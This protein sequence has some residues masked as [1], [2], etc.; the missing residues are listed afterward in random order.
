[1]FDKHFQFV[2]TKEEAQSSFETIKQES[3]VEEY[4]TKFEI[5]APK[6][7]YNTEA[8][9]PFFKKGLKPSILDNVYR[10]H[11]VA[12]DLVTWKLYTLA[13]EKQAHNRKKEKERWGGQPGSACHGVHFNTF[14]RYSQ[15]PL[16]PRRP[17]PSLPRKQLWLNTSQWTLMRSDVGCSRSTRRNIWS[18]SGRCFYCRKSAARHAAQ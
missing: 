10:I 9:I 17:Q 13:V 18:T 15:R 6:T 7:K 8:Q 14:F 1:M 5:L 3:S 4:I 2:D 16:A 11:P 12:T